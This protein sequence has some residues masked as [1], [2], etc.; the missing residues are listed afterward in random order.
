MEGLTHA[1]DVHPQELGKPAGEIEIDPA[2]RPIVYYPP[3]R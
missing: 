1:G 3:P 2:V